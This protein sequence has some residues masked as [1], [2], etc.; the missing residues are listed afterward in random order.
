MLSLSLELVLGVQNN[1][2]G[3]DFEPQILLLNANL[4]TRT[5]KPRRTRT[6]VEHRVRSD[7]KLLVEFSEIKYS[8]NILV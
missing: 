8:Y 4:G 2:A 1:N 7:P 6:L 5:T 3:P